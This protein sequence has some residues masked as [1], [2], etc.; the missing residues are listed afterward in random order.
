MPFFSI[1]IPV[2]NASLYVKK[3]IDSI[4]SQE[5]EDY[6]VLMI[7]DG[8][9]DGSLQILKQYAE[10]DKR[11]RVFHQVNQGP[12]KARNCGLD[13]AHGQWILFVD[14]DDYFYMSQALYSLYEAIRKNE[15]CQLVYFPGAVEIDGERYSDSLRSATFSQGVI[16][17]E[18]NCPPSKSIVF[19]SLYVQCFRKQVIDSMHLRFAEDIVYGEDRLFVCSY[20]LYAGKTIV[21]PDCL[22]VYVV[23]STSLMHDVQRLKRSSSDT[24]KVAYLL[25]KEM[26]RSG[27]KCP[28]LRKYIHGLYV[29][30]VRNMPRR[31]I[32]WFFIFRNASTW[33][34][35]IKDMLMFIGIYTY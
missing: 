5:F 8:S 30:G 29:G 26:I 27:K 20:Y 13:K 24:Q 17:M 3:C 1:I 33:K 19:G 23:N 32:D 28:H 15:D 31:A 18:E 14:A 12:S 22:Y 2:Y 6:E 9:T 11:I 4:L 21:L 34:L 35:K 16:C 7:D 10:K 25:E